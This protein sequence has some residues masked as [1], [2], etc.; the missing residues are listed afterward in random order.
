MNNGEVE[1]FGIIR[2]EI[3]EIKIDKIVDGEEVAGRLMVR[4]K[5]AELGGILR[6]DG[7]GTLV[8]NLTEQEKKQAERQAK[9]RSWKEKLR[10]LV[11]KDEWVGKAGV[12]KIKF[13]DGYLL[14]PVLLPFMWADVTIAFL[15]EV[16]DLAGVHQAADRGGKL[17]VAGTHTLIP[18]RLFPKTLRPGYAVKVSLG[19]LA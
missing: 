12:M 10:A 16:I 1:T 14:P 13:H 3:R 2:I 6:L 8:P 4:Y 15:G 9:S 18:W 5:S 11:K 7:N 17:A 19:P